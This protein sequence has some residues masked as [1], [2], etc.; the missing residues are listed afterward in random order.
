M[1]TRI[2]LVLG[3]VILIVALVL[4]LGGPADDIKMSHETADALAAARDRNREVSAKRASTPPSP[5]TTIATSRME[6]VPPSQRTDFKRFAKGPDLAIPTESPARHDWLAMSDAVDRVLEAAENS[7]RDWVF[8]WVQVAPGFDRTQLSEHWQESNVQAIGFSGEFA[9]VR[10]ASSRDAI[11]ALI[12]HPGVVG[13]GIQPPEQK[14]SPRFASLKH[15]PTTELPVLISLMEA[16]TDGRWGADLEMN[17]VIVGEW[18]PYARA[19]SANIRVDAIPSLVEFD[20]VTFIEPVEIFQVLL[21]TAVPAM[22]VDGVRTYDEATGTYTGSTGE[23]VP[24]GVV[25]TGLNIAHADIATNRTSVCGGNFFPDDGGDGDFDLWSDFGGHGTHVTGII[26]GNGSANSQFAGMAPLIQHI[27]IAKVLNRNGTGDAVTVANGVRYLLGESAC[28]WEGRQTEAFKPLIMNMSLGGPGERDGSGASNRNIDAVISHGTQL[29]VIAAGNDGENGT[30]N[31]ATAKNV[32]A[33]GAV[34]DA[35]VVNGFSSHG[36]TADGRL[37]PHVVGTGS[38]INSA[39]GNSSTESYVRY[40]G[41]S[42]A[43]PAVAG[44]AA[45]LMDQNPEFRNAPAY[46]KARLMSSAVKPGHTLGQAGFPLSNSDGPG[47]FN[48]E[49]GLGLVSASVAIQDSADGYWSHGGDHGTVEPGETFEYQIDIPEDTARI[50]IVLT[51]IESPSEAVAPATV[52]ANLDL[53]LDKDGDCGATACGEFASTSPIDN[54]EWIIVKD[55]EPGSYSLRF[56]ATN[57]FADPV[58]AGISWTT[59]ANRDAPTLA[60][61]AQEQSLAIETGS[62]FDV[63]LDLN[64]DGFLS[65]GTT[66]HMVCRSESDTGCAGY[67]DANWL[68]SSHVNR[69]DSTRTKVDTPFGVT[70]P[71]GEVSVGD[72]RSVSLAVP[73]GIATEGHTLFFIASSWNAESDVVSVGV[74][75]DGS[76]SV[77]QATR[78][79]ND[80]ITDARMLEGESGEFTFDLLLA[81][82]EPGE[83]MLRF[84]DAGSGVKKFFS[85]ASLNQRN[86]DEEMQS[87]A[88]HGSVWFRIK[89][90]RSGPYRI[91]IGP[92]QMSEGTWLAVYEGA[93]PLDSN[94]I[95]AYEGETEF[96]AEAGKSYFVQAWTEATVRPLLR[97]T[98]NQIEERRP[99]NDD[100]EDR[101]TLSGSRGVVAGTNYR[102]TLEN[103]EF[104]GI[105]AVGAS[106]WFR[107]IASETGRYEFEVSDGLR[108]FVFDGT[109]TR[110]LRRVSTMPNRYGNSQFEATQDREYQIVVLDSAVRLIPDYQL[111]WRSIGTPSFSYAENDMMRAATT[112]EGTTGEVSIDSFDARTVEPNEDAR[113]G[114]GTGWWRWSPPAG[115]NYVFRLNGSG[116][117]QLSVFSGTSLDDM[118]FVDVGEIL[119]ASTLQERQYWIAVG[120]RSD[121]MFADIDGI[122]LPDSFSWGPLPT[123]DLFSTPGSLSGTT[124]KVTADH[125][126]ATSSIEEFGHIRG[127]S[128]LWWRWVAPSTGWQRFELQAWEAAGLE[129]E[130]QQGIVAVYHE[131][132]ESTPTLISTSDHS[133]MANG[134]AEATIR[135]EEGEAY[136]VRVAL[137]STYLG[138]W[139]PELTFSYEPVDP[140]VWQ[141]YVGR[142]VEVGGI[143]DDVEDES[144]YQPR[145]VSIVDQS[146]LI[147]IATRDGLVAYEEESDGSLSRAAITPYLNAT[148]APVEIADDFLL[149]W[150]A[151]SDRLYLVQRN[152]VFEISDPISKASRLTR[153]TPNNLNAVIPE[154]AHVD[155][156]SKNMYVL[157]EREVN[158]FAIRASCEFELIQTV[159]SEF[160]IGS[161]IPHLRMNEL[162]GARTIAL[163]PS[164]DRVYAA[165]GDALVTMRRMNDGTLSREATNHVQQWAMDYSFA[166]ARA[167][168]VLGSADTLF[169]IADTSPVV[170]VFDTSDQSEGENPEVLDIVGAFY[171][172]QEDFH[173]VPYYSHVEW[174]QRSEGCTAT[175]SYREEIP[176]VDVFCDNQVFTVSWNQSEDTLVVT[177]WFQLDQADR[178]GHFIR[179]GVNTL[180]PKQ[181]VE[182]AQANRNYVLGE[183]PIGTLHIFDRA[184]RITDNPYTQ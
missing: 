127:H 34:T 166:F 51:W 22:G 90:E 19:Y 178:F 177:D 81:T 65:A 143:D 17:G 103:F 108:S 157:G 147:G 1:G 131:G 15:S 58:H 24:I 37:N 180:S 102:A 66:L 161:N 99:E 67:E 134:R 28:E 112:I 141:R 45:L 61:S 140:P 158:V 123:N 126:F 84:E 106:T 175:S 170:A 109:N 153:C 64:I 130:S 21:D 62:S 53:Y 97:L 46:A 92:D 164:D 33:V 20:Y 68:P 167:S 113:T 3:V 26:A 116:V 2:A 27:R 11:E 181:I 98:W 43:A 70:V 100:F 95:S 168:V 13:V 118:K 40:R 89:A 111:S 4:D 63:N 9:R 151:N 16:D 160:K 88:R 12:E 93:T 91:R 120:Y 32:L 104:Y 30:S 79:V 48:D 159:G 184:T 42:M 173:S 29:M 82:R 107:W 57:D 152:G 137:R 171:L 183:S 86:F 174:P 18:L 162:D 176:A 71:I 56:M 73:R 59:I 85:D 47:A 75:P 83:P 122:G 121:S 146:G 119:Q 76:E 149:H 179:A 148:G 172:S 114:V 165:G 7:G 110:S 124:G 72:G 31:E 5:H 117:G 156:D 69:R 133:Y 39:K 87:Y 94:R 145:S 78:P 132:R 125:S 105:E 74:T 41:T 139:K 182:N 128:S 129:E 8:G 23:S 115:G 35:G 38:A 154:Q 50:D 142:I 55:P 6:P 150:D 169:V 96:R 138:E 163:N 135:A 25:D 80:S 101:T 155:A 144:L 44:V 77:V 54:V 36:P 14:I 52:V 49:Y 136:I 60:I 10:I